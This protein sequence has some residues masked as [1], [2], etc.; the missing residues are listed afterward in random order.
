MML[1]DSF[2]LKANIRINVDEVYEVKHWA[3]QLGVSIERLQAVIAQ[4]GPLVD[5]V[6]LYL[7]DEMH[8]DNPW[9]P[10]AG[11][12]QANRLG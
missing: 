8:P 5:A 9:Y 3:K 12:P 6:R 4:A 11:Q 2:S 7:K 1:Q 10:R